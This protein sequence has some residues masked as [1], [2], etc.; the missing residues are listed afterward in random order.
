MPVDAFS[1]RTKRGATATVWTYGATLVDMTTPDRHGELNSVV[2]RLP[3]LPSYEDRATNP[4][5]MGAI[6]GRYG[7][8]IAHGRFMLDDVTHQLDRNIGGHHFHGGSAGFD[9]FVWTADAEVRGDA[10]VLDLSLTRPDGDQGYPGAMA[11]GVRYEMAETGDLTLTFTATTSRSTI[12]GLTGHA[13]WNLGGAGA[14]DGHRLAVNARRVVA[15]DDGLIPTGDLTS[16]QDA[17]LDWTAERP[18]G[19]ARLDHCFVLDEGPWAA[20]LRDPRS[21]RMMEILT[22][23]PG[24]A[25]YSADLLAS[26]RSGL[27]L[28]TGPLADSPNQPG[29]PSSR[30]DPGCVYRHRTTFRFRIK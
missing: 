27:C 2:L 11:A 13:F 8:C 21:G 20:R 16:V 7:R 29:F 12:V 24:L 19:A 4:S 15:T 22:D 6:L 30:L 25:V 9:R 18:I 28:Q 14:I 10:A 17:G 3:D 26:A 5:Y 23:Q 1:L